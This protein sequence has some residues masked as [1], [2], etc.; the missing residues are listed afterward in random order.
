VAGLRREAW[1]V[2]EPASERKFK[3]ER[4]ALAVQRGSRTGAVLARLWHQTVRVSSTTAFVARSVVDASH[5]C[6]AAD[7]GG[8]GLYHLCCLPVLARWQGG[9]ARG[10][11][12][13]GAYRPQRHCDHAAALDAVPPSSRDSTSF[14]LGST[15]T[16]VLLPPS[17]QRYNKSPQKRTKNNSRWETSKV[18]HRNPLRAIEEARCGGSSGGLSVGMLRVQALLGEASAGARR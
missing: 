16:L 18:G 14:S 17:P 15:T 12:D 6:M 5:S 10:R 1:S 9:S 8:A 13:A 7:P 2:Q 3:S 4:H 11:E